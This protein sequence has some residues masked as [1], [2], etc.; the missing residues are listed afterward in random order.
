MNQ[1]FSRFA[2]RATDAVGSSTTFVVAFILVVGWVLGGVLWFGFGDNYQL[3]INTISTIS[4]GLIVFL[5]QNSQNRD[6]RAMHVKLDA[7][8]AQTESIDNQYVAIEQET[9]QEIN[10]KEQ[11]LTTH[12]EGE[13]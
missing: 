7:I 9:M 2:K 12:L 3:W 6:M 4:T 8:I 1:F 5:I 10:A 13:S 11:Q